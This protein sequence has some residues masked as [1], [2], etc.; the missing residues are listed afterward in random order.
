MQVSAAVVP[1]HV[2]RDV[3]PRTPAVYPD[4][5]LTSGRE[6]PPSQ[7]VHAAT[8][9]C[10]DFLAEEPNQSEHHGGHDDRERS[11]RRRSAVARSGPLAAAGNV[12]VI[13]SSP[14]IAIAPMSRPIPRA[15]DRRWFG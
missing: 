15:P 3:E 4:R 10:A 1:L 5:D 6:R 7:D 2:G 9:I 14:A 13:E 12:A 11:P 8:S